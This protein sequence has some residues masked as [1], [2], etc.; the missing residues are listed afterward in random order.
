[1]QRQTIVQY[2]VQT[3]TLAC[4]TPVALP[5]AELQLPLTPTPAQTPPLTVDWPR[6]ASLYIHKPGPPIG[7]TTGEPAKLIGRKNR[8]QAVILGQCKAATLIGRQNR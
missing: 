6:T 5:A 3:R 4:L 8:Q 2:H 1:M 7:R